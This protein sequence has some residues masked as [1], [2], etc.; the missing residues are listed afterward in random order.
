MICTWQRK[1]FVFVPLFD[2]THIIEIII[3]AQ[4]GNIGNPI[5]ITKYLPSSGPEQLNDHHP[6]HRPESQPH[7][8]Q[9]QN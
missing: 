4:H 3:G 6:Q 1:S 8:H 7:R 2:F 9:V 5:L